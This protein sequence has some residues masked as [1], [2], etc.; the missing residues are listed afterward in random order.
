VRPDHQRSYARPARREEDD[1]FEKLTTLHPQ[2]RLRLEHE[3][4]LSCRVIDLV[5]PIGKGQRGLIVSPPRAGKTTTLQ[6][7]AKGILTNN[8]DVAVF[9]LLVNERPEEVT[10]MQR[11]GFGEVLYSSFDRPETH[12][13]EV[14]EKLLARAK[15]LVLEKKDVV[16]LLDS[17]TRLARAYNGQTS[18]GKLMSGGMDAKGMFKPKKF[19]GAARAMEVGGSL[20]II[21]TALVD[22]GSRMDDLI[23]EEF[24]GTGNME[25]H[26]DRKLM[27]K[28]LFPCVDIKRSGTRKEELL[29]DEN[30][31]AASRMLRERLF[32]L[33][34][35]GAM[36]TLLS[37]LER[38]E[39]NA[40]FLSR[41]KA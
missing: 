15:K 35:V 28:R 39:T 22:T 2:E 23:F 26:L 37:H 34:T 19:F 38:T 1:R 18:S 36:E 25:L 24:K 17:L 32:S 8:P 9:T 5:A 7:I 13:I 6:R 41:L 29:L 3:G 11:N 14:A 33:D 27:E 40:E 12:H 4:D 30:E 20:T 31:L 10:D 16:I 21:A